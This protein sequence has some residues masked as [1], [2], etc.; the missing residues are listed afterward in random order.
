MCVCKWNLGRSQ[1]WG[2]GEEKIFQ[3]PWCNEAEADLLLVEY[4]NLS[5]RLKY[6]EITSWCDIL[7]LANIGLFLVDIE[8][9]IENAPQDK[10]KNII[11]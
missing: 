6:N 7:I 8:L 9:N 2:G 11:F 4:T 1:W 10:G 5:S 3:K